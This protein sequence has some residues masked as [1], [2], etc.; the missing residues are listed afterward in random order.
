[1][2]PLRILPYTC[3][4]SQVGPREVGTFSW[5]RYPYRQGSTNLP[6][7]YHRKLFPGV[8]HKSP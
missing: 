3:L 6:G 2:H 8:Y 1:M 7:F 5:A 4:R